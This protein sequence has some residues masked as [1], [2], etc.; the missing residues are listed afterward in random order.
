[1][2]RVEMSYPDYSDLYHYG[3]PRGWAVINTL[4]HLHVG[5][6]DGYGGGYSYSG[7]GGGMGCKYASGYFGDDR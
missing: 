4:G 1:M 2:T 3:L 6:S 7:D 5:I